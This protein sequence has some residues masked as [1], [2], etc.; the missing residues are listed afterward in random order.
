MIR[1]AS[2]ISGY[3]RR[4]EANAETFNQGWMK[5]GDVAYFDEDGLFYIVDRI[6]ELIKVKGLQVSLQFSNIKLEKHS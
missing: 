6:K 4:P 1:G 2:V 5:T 3:W